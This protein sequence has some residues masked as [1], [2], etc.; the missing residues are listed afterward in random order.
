MGCCV[1]KQDSLAAARDSIGSQ[2]VRPYLHARPPSLSA[3][4]QEAGPAAPKFKLAKV[5]LHMWHQV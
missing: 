5:V 1:Q 2:D 4:R 3:N